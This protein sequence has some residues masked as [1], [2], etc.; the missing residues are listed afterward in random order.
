VRDIEAVRSAFGYDRLNLVAASYGVRV[1]SAYMR[2]HPRRVRS[3]TLRAAYAPDYNIIRD[4]LGNADKE[5]GRVIDGCMAE[6]ACA[7]AFPR[8]EA[9]LQ[10]LDE[11]L[12]HDPARLTVKGANGAQEQILVGRELLQQILYAMLLAAPTRQMLPL[13]IDTASRKGFE[14]LA[15]MVVQVRDALYGA[16]PV[17]MY[18]SVVCSEDAARL[19]PQELPSGRTP[20]S[21]SAAVLFRACDAWPKAVV[22]AAFFTPRKIEVPTLIL[23]G[24]LDPATTVAAANRLA[25]SLPLS[26]HVVLKATSHGPLFPACAT[27]SVASFIESASVSNAAPD[28]SGLALAPFAVT[29]PAAR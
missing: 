29:P 22:P 13:I 15:P 7:A 25:A 14:P 9:Q 23:S 20:L 12:A 28:C 3:A 6:A 2:E 16:L 11:K 8:L 21:R 27:K 1:A 5:L 10:A 4:G 26:R 18:L 24:E 17:G 19:R